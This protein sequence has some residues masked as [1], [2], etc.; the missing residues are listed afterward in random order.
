M[1]SMKKYLIFGAGFASYCGILELGF[2]RFSSFLAS[3]FLTF[4]LM[5]WL[6]YVLIIFRGLKRLKYGDLGSKHCK[7]GFKRMGKV[8][9]PLEK[10]LSDHTMAGKDGL[11]SSWR[12]VVG[13]VVR[14]CSTCLYQNGHKFLLG[15][16]ILAR[17]V[18][19]ES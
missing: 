4:D 11:S 3:S 14:T 15:C 10:L 1:K 8:K 7:L 9:R 17:S 2:L 16:L 5:I 12:P 18:D 19:M 13:S 6:R